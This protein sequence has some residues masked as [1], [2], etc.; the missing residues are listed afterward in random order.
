MPFRA[1]PRPV[2]PPATYQDQRQNLAADNY[3]CALRAMSI[4]GHLERLQRRGGAL[5][6]P[7]LTRRSCRPSKP[8]CVCR[9]AAPWPSFVRRRT[10]WK[11]AGQPS[12][13]KGNRAAL[14]LTTPAP[15]S[16]RRIHTL[17]R[18]VVLRHPN[19]LSNRKIVCRDSLVASWRLGADGY[20]RVYD[21]A[22]ITTGK[23]ALHWIS[24]LW[25]WRWLTCY[26]SSP[27]P[28]GRSR[29]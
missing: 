22:K 8:L 9:E 27:A 25:G 18:R 26:S 14:H 17:R 13:R 4:K 10:I 5:R 24:L 23:E 2:T 3:A 12:G 20:V 16:D 15:K 6:G 11:A 19:I 28:P 29:F 21:T 7:I 1:L